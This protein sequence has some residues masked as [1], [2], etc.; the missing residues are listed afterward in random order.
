MNSWPWLFDSSFYSAVEII[1]EP[2]KKIP[3]STLHLCEELVPNSGSL[4]GK[5]ICCGKQCCICHLKS[6]LEL[7]RDGEFQPERPKNSCPALLNAISRRTSIFPP[8]T[9]LLLPVTLASSECCWATSGSA[10]G[11]GIA[12]TP[13]GQP[14]G[15]SRKSGS[16]CAWR[17]SPS[18]GSPWP[19][20]RAGG[21]WTRLGTSLDTHPASSRA[22][23]AVHQ[24]AGES[25]TPRQARRPPFPT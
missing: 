8:P 3:N 22:C 25:P 24:L 14:C 5:N 18:G 16:S 9:S 21:A 20:S 17:W 11:R 12:P 7:D 15:S 2:E 23:R 10:G 4:F 19:Y 13:G 6:L 1:L